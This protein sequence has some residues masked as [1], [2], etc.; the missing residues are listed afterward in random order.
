MYDD[1][2]IER[3]VHNQSARWQAIN[4]ICNEHE[5]LEALLFDNNGRAGV[6]LIEL[7]VESTDFERWSER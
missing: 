6:E 7:W 2:L 1:E 5:A 4:W 3:L